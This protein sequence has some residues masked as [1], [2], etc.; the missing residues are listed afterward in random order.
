MFSS[1][2][3]V[4]SYGKSNVKEESWECCGAVEVGAQNLV[5]ITDGVIVEQKPCRQKT[6]RNAEN[7]VVVVWGMDKSGQMA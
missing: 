7:S 3:G 4:K 1:L 5:C 6:V 2:E